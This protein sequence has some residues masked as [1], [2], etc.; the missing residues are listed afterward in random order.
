MA[1]LAPQPHSRRAVPA[2]YGTNRAR[3][4]RVKPPGSSRAGAA[5]GEEQPSPG[6]AISMR[7]RV[8]GRHGWRG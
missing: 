2:P 5:G 6:R 7:H 1:V 8:R 3:G 4:T